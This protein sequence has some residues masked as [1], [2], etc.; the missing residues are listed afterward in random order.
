V[1][2]SV[3]ASLIEGRRVDFKIL[4]SFRYGDEKVRC[5]STAHRPHSLLYPFQKHP[6]W[7]PL[8]TYSTERKCFWTT[9]DEMLLGLSEETYEATKLCRR[10][11]HDVSRGSANVV[12]KVKFL[13]VWIRAA[14]H[15][16]NMSY[17]HQ[18]LR[19]IACCLCKQKTFVW[20]II[21]EGNIG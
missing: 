19:S 21:T 15:Y 14:I 20:V 7:L 4:T 17:S 18:F 3:P 6:K 12:T 2:M 11:V 16:W 9:V 1:S 8:L 13:S 5:R 10:Q